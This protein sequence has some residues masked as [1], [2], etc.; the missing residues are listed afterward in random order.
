MNEYNSSELVLIG[1]GGNSKVFRPQND[2][3]GVV[4]KRPNWRHDVDALLTKYNRL[5]SL[6]IPTLLFMRKCAVDGVEAIECEDMSSGEMDY[7][8]PN[9]VE[10]ETDRYRRLLSNKMSVLTPTAHVENV[11]EQRWYRDKLNSI[12]NIHEFLVQANKNLEKITKN[13]IKVEYDSYFFGFSKKGGDVELGLKIADLDNI[14]FDCKDINL[15]Q[16][17]ISDFNEALKKFVNMFVAENNQG[18][19]IDAI[20]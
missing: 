15:L 14:Y 19:L 18:P 5:A 10:T 11:C 4:I 9:S 17:N 12:T 13:K 3:I 8:S 16:K 7:V 1:G 20:R 2:N 6:G